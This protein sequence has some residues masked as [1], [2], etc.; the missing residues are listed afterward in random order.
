MWDE[1]NFPQEI[2][3]ASDV[4]QILANKRYS[5][6]LYVPEELRAEAEGFF[7]NA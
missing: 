3:D 4:V 7:T 2:I 5:S 6:R 1:R